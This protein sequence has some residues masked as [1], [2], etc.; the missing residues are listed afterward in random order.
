LIKRRNSTLLD[1]IDDY[2]LDKAGA[3]VLYHSGATYGI[4]RTSSIQAKVGDGHL[5][6]KDLQMRIDSGAEWT[7]VFQEAWRIERDCFW[8]ANMGGIDWVKIGKKYEVLMPWVAS[9]DDLNYVIGQYDRRTGY[10]AL[11]CRG[12]RWQ[13]SDPSRFRRAWCRTTR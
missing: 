10:I 3:L 6:S 12:R 7:D 13:A 1:G 2:D 11:L 4:V 8:D 9:R 5:N